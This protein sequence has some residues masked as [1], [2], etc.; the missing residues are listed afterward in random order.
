M[1]SAIP[2]KTPQEAAN[3][4]IN[5][6]WV[7]SLSSGWPVGQSWGAKEKAKWTTCKRRAWSHPQNGPELFSNMSSGAPSAKLH[8]DPT[9]RFPAFSLFA[10]LESSRVWQKG[11]VADEA[12]GDGGAT[13]GS[14]WGIPRGLLRTPGRSPCPDSPW[15]KE[16]GNSNLSRKLPYTLHLADGQ[17][18]FKLNR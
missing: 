5:S 2:V 6:V 18:G 11:L 12:S 7:L 17:M 14:R 3:S 15:V 4:L 13:W 16:E 10:V 9:S 8:R 1:D